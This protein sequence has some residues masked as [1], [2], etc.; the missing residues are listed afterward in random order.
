M[1]IVGP[2]T[3]TPSP[4]INENS[5]F[6]PSVLSVAPLVDLRAEF[7][8]SSYSVF[9][10]KQCTVAFGAGH[11]AAGVNLTTLPFVSKVPSTASPPFCLIVIPSATVNGLTLFEKT[12]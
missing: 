9:A 4:V 1:L 7:I 12:S 6:P 8:L 3:S 5:F 11:K 2:F 10:A